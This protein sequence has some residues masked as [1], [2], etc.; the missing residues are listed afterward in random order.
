MAGIQLQFEAAQG[1]SEQ[2]Q[3]VGHV[4]SVSGSKIRGVLAVADHGRANGYALEAGRALQIGNLVKIPMP[5]SVAFGLV[6]KLEIRD[7]TGPPNGTDCRM[8]EIDL[9]GESLRNG[10]ADAME[11]DDHSAFQ[12]GIS[13]YPGLGDEIHTASTGELGQIYK[14][15]T[16]P[17]VRMGTLHQ[18]HDLPV[19][20]M[21][22]ELLGKHFAIFG[23]SGSG[24]SCALAVILHAILDDHSGGHV[25][26]LDPHNEYGHAF[27]ER[28]DVITTDELHLPFWLLNF[29]ELVEVL[30]SPDPESRESEVGIL[31]SAVIAAKQS[32]AGDGEMATF[33]TVDTPVPYRLST[34]VEIID[35]AMGD[36]EKAEQ[37]RP[38][39]RL[40]AR[41]GRLRSDRRFAF[42]FAGLSVH[43]SMADVMSRILRIP[44]DGKPVTLFDLSAVPSEIIDVLVSLLCRII[45]DFAMWSERALTV[46]VLVVCEE[47]HRY[48]PCDPELGFGPTRKAISRIAKEGRKYGVSLCLVTQRP[49]E[50]SQ[51]ILSQCNTLFALRM[52]NDRDQEFVRRALPESAA[53]MLNALPALRTQ[54]AVVVG[55]GVTLPMRVRFDHLK[56][57][58]R[59]LSETASFSSAWRQDVDRGEDFVATTL[60]RWRRQAR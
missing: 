43:D 51:T 59:P 21:T 1:M 20:L 41:I 28:A 37:T 29:E 34:L 25:V 35:R 39:L 52:S 13:V 46:P 24:K 7:P 10:A 50:L 23:T 26:L 17:S 5:K 14:R 27:G 11:G 54:E 42:M 12:R 6:S 22:D 33:L 56:G 2:A 16:E 45:F 15:P 44:V 58:H 9:F 31:K 55:E 57:V 4:V 30:C 19:Y 49:S 60:D 3:K 47:A 48:I 38:Y 36:F 18:D 53:G 32:F 8:V 40:K